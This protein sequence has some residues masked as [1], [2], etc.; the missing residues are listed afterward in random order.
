[1]GL[2]CIAI[3]GRDGGQLRALSDVSIVVPSYDTQ[4]IQEVQ[5]LVI[6]LLCELIEEQVMS[7][8]RPQVAPLAT[9]RNM[10]EV[11]SLDQKASVATRTRNA[12][13]PSRAAK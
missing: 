10:W 2:R 13:T 8:R 4:H 7:G 5:A 11:G 9:I 1:M 3:L 6:H 12:A